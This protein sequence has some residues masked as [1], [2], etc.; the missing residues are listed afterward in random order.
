LVTTLAAQPTHVREILPAQDPDY[1][2]YCDAS[3]FGAGSVWFSGTSSVHKRVW[4]LQWPQD[5]TAAVVSESNP[6]GALTNSD[7]EMAAVVLHLNVLDPLVPS[8]HH[9]SMQIHRD[10]TPSVAWLTEMATKTANSDAAHR[11]VRG[12]ALRQQML[13]SAPVSITH[14]AGADNN[15]ADIASRAIT[16]LDDAHAFLTRFDNLFPLQERFWQHASP[17]PAQ[18]SNVISTLRG[19]SLTMQ[20]WTVPLAPPAGAG[21]NNTAP[22]V[23]RI[24]GCATRALNIGAQY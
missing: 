5:I 9:K 12:L 17:P 3:A 23:E 19:H 6:T 14:V 18:L 8:M 4:R 11:L 24:H 22:I 13:H 20:R 15:L 16:Q 2:G 7:L 10:N 1:I 21:G